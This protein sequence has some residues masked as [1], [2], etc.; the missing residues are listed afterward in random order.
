MAK[1]SQGKTPQTGS[2]A[3]NRVQM[4]PDKS[5]DRGIGSSFAYAVQIMKEEA[6]QFRGSQ[7]GFLGQKSETIDV[8][9]FVESLKGK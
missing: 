9:Q 7:Q 2:K 4:T 8:Q 1:K 6:K 3:D 5:K